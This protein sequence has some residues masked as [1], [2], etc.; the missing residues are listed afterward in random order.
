MSDKVFYIEAPL[1]GTFYRRPSP[2]EDPYV[3]IGDNVNKGDVVCIVE[4]MKIFNE[5]RTEKH[6]II[7]E[8]LVEDEDPVIIHQPM[9]KV[10]AI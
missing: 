2:E 10:E 6:G 7:R 8:I 9:F 1:A 4:T 5:V 3:E